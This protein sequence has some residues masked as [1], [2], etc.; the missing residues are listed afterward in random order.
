MWIHLAA[1]ERSRKEGVGETERLTP[2]GKQDLF[3]VFILF[4]FH[5]LSCLQVSF[6]CEHHSLCLVLPPS[7]TSLIINW[8]SSSL[9]PTVRPWSVGN[10]HTLS[11]VPFVTA[12]NGDFAPFHIKHSPPLILLTRLVVCL[13]KPLVTL[14]ERRMNIDGVVACVRFCLRIE[15]TTSW[16]VWWFS[17]VHFELRLLDPPWWGDDVDLISW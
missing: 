7:L 11:R 16:G 17:G 14:T 10:P 13:T 6:F 4:Y 1:H 5:T 2:P 3:V 15:R 8:L 9:M 12:D